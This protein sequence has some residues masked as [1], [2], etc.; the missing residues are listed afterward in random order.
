LVEVGNGPLATTV[1]S[2]RVIGWLPSL[3]YDPVVVADVPG[4]VV[5]RIL[6]AVLDEA[7]RL[8]AEGVPIDR[9]DQAG[10]VMLPP[11]GPLT[12]IDRFGISHVAHG[13]RRL[14]P[15]A[16]TGLSFYRPGR[17]GRL[18]PN[19]EAGAL[20]WESR[21]QAAVVEPECNV[22]RPAGDLPP[23]KQALEIA[24]RLE[25]RAINEAARCL[26]ADPFTTAVEIDLLA[27]EGAGVFEQAGGPLGVADGRGLV[28]CVRSLSR[29]AGRF[30]PRFAPCPGL[31]RRSSAGGFFRTPA[32]L[33]TLR[34]VR[35]RVA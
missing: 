4:L 29:L 26:H 15:L 1:A 19:A 22:V 12:L 11:G 17:Y 7:V 32:P 9:I 24:D 16:A 10:G 2:S 33:P 30:G 20:L 13:V 14:V 35:R 23:V 31:V 8:A 21:F 25:Y 18:V 3:G 5:R 34:P 28:T 6:F 27:A